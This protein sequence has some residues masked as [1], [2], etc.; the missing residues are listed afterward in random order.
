MREPRTGTVRPEAGEPLNLEIGVARLLWVGTLVGV[1]LLLVGIG[2]MARAGV[3]PTA[4]GYIPFDPARIV[5]DLTSLRPDGFLWAGIVV[6]IATPV[7]RVAGGLLAFTV[8]GDGR[9]A[10]VALAILGVIG[11]S[12]A[13]AMATEV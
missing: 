4:G 6:L 10:L 13:L 9:M 5:G 7:V 11:L 12:V 1:A 8:R 2:L 3:D